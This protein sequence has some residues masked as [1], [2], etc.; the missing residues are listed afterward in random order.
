MQKNPLFRKGLAVGISTV[1]VIFLILASLT[2]VIGYQTVQSSNQQIIKEEVNQRELLFQ[3]ILDIA[4]NK[5]IQRIILKSQMSKGIFPISNIPVLTKNQ[6]KRMYF[7]GLILSKFISKARIQSMVH[8]DQLITPEIQQEINAII[9]KDSPLKDEITQL[10]N[11]DCGCEKIEWGFPI[12]CT[13]LLIMMGLV[14]I[15]WLLLMVFLMIPP[16]ALDEMLGLLALFLEPLLV[17]Y[18]RFNC[19]IPEGNDFPYISDI[20]PANGEQ[21]VLL[22]LTE[23]R[24]R[25]TDP[26]GDP[27]SYKV[28]TS[29]YIGEGNGTLVPNGTYIIPIHGLQPS[30]SYSWQLYLYA[31]GPTGTPLA[32]TYTFTTAPLAP[33]IGNPSP[34]HNA[35]YVPISQSN[36]SFDLKDFQGDLMNWTVETQP[37]IGSGGAQGIGNG[38]YTVAI[39]GLEYDKKYTWF[40]NATD[41]TYWT[42][43]TYNFSTTYDGLMVLEPR[44]DTMVYAYQPNDNWGSM[45]FI[46]TYNNNRSLG[47]VLF[48][49]LGIPAGSTIISANLSL[50]YYEYTLEIPVG[51]EITCH[52]I[53]EHWD[54][55]TVTFNTMPDSNPVKC[56]NMTVPENYTWV[57]WNVTSEVDDFINHGAVNNGWMLRDNKPYSTHNINECYYSSDA[58]SHHPRLFIWFDSP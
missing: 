50:F 13:T 51:R 12:I 1:L 17:L 7:I 53:L 33:D 25:L 5:E 15:P 43:K 46:E 9:E 44:A 14:F 18:Q 26:E 20:S 36:V 55:M 56:A 54:E 28:T 42:R 11:S 6:L 21:N 47:M 4:S 40:V 2:N 22:N 57:N 23:L 31:G 8:T 27:M 49:L 32:P 48:N 45:Y 10:V 52:R 24:F 34:K 19:P 39:S 41:G 3:T 35:Q 16:S 37:N 38:Q 29:P 58:A 30:T